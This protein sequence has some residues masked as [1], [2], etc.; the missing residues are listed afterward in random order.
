MIIAASATG[1]SSLLAIQVQPA[2]WPF[3]LPLVA[4][5]FY[6]KG[7]FNLNTAINAERNGWFHCYY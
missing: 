4:F 5:P 7:C 1:S 2:T 3:I 6:N